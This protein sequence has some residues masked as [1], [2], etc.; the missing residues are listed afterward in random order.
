MAEELVTSGR[1]RSPVPVLNTVG[2]AATMTNPAAHMPVPD[3]GQMSERA[4]R[5]YLLMHPDVLQLST[6]GPHTMKHETWVGSELVPTPGQRSTVFILGAIALVL[7]GVIGGYVVFMVA[8]IIYMVCYSGGLKSESMAGC[9]ERLGFVTNVFAQ[10][11]CR[12]HMMCCFNGRFHIFGLIMNGEAAQTL[13]L[14]KKLNGGAGPAPGGVCW[15]GDSEFTFWL[16]LRE[17]MAPFH[18]NCFNAGFGGARLCD[19]LHNLKRLCLRWEPRIVIVHAGGN[20][21][22]TDPTLRAEEIPQKARL[23]CA[24]SH[25]SP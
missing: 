8:L 21:L 15:I 10:S 13:G 16:N 25:A 9:V 12:M 20:D 22:D 18:P 2:P 6:L 5:R 17:D 24:S 19:V 3:F 11:V 4:F 23:T 7:S 14:I 1:P